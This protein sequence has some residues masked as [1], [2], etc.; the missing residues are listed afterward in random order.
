LLDNGPAKFD[1][2]AE[3]LLGVFLSRDLFVVRGHD[4][5]QAF[6]DR[7]Q[8]V[9]RYTVRDQWVIVARVARCTLH[10]G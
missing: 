1:D 2:F 6:P 5:S 9:L 10:I 7:I 4:R 8:Q 3:L